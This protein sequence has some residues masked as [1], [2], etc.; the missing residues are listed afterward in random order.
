MEHGKL[1]QTVKLQSAI[2]PFQC[3]EVT[4]FLPKSPSGW[5]LGWGKGGEQLEVGDVDTSG[6]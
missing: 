2:G 6:E 5:E 1:V 3:T 4:Q